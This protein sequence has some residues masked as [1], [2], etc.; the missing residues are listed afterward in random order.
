MITPAFQLCLNAL[1]RQK[2]RGE[3]D[4]GL[5]KTKFTVL[6]AARNAESLLLRN[7]FQMVDKVHGDG[8]LTVKYFLDTVLKG[9]KLPNDVQLGP[10]TEKVIRDAISP[11]SSKGWFNWQN[12]KSAVTGMKT[13]VLVCGPDG[14]TKYISGEHGGAVSRQ[15]EKGGLLKNV[16]GI[17]VF[18]MLDSRDGETPVDSRK[19]KRGM[20]VMKI[21]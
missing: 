3:V 9:I 4:A 6:A 11:P 10:I 1:Q 19:A 17:E 7:E 8:L 14:F 12:Q 21:D 16:D 15:G 2:L 20:P 5:K 13:I 18:K